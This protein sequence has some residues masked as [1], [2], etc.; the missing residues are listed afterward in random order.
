M[1]GAPSTSAAVP[2]TGSRKHAK[3]SKLSNASQA[4]Q[5]M[6]VPRICHEKAIK[7]SKD[8]ITRRDGCKS[9][10]VANAIELLKLVFLSTSS[11]SEVQAS[12]TAT[13][14]LYSE[15]EIVTAFSFLSDK[16]FTVSIC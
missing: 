15:S 9:L 10:A 13:L 8:E 4:S 6:D 3:L 16:K 14:Q 12:L 5:S 1:Q 7:V 2:E 11:G